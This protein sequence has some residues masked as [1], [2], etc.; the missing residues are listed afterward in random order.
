MAA[1]SSALRRD[2]VLV[3]GG[4]AHVQVLLRL[5]EEPPAG[6]RVTLVVDRPLA[7]YSGMVPGFIAGQY[8]R[9]E[10]EID[11]RPLAQRAGARVVLAPMTGLD[12]QARRIRVAGLPSIRFDVASLDVGS[13]VGGLDLP[14]VREHAL[15]TRPIGAFVQRVEGALARTA[16]GPNYPLRLLVVGGGAGGVEIAFTLLQRL[17]RGGAAARAT[18]VSAGKGILA[19]HSASLANRVLRRARGVGI[20]I[21]HGA[22][23]VAVEPQGLVCSDGT[24]EPFDILAW[25]TGAVANPALAGVELPK[26]ERGFLHTRA[27]LEVEGCGGLFAAGD[28]AHL[29]DFPRT[30]RAGAYAVRQGPVL[31][32]NL[33]AALAGG[34]LTATGRRPISSCCSTSATGPRSAA[35]GVCRS[36]ARG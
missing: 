33:M 7:V 20:E 28:C 10:L 5:A 30:P 4:H 26:D 12:A 27:T 3:G 23:A 15:P 24:R 34:H 29:V 14:G 19:G 35:S 6:T 32:R 25:V 36:R 1:L 22:R 18:L 13:T 2:L 17:R 16:A 21:R 8:R 9:E 11:V 31:A